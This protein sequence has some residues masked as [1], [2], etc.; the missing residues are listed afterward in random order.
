M[1]SKPHGWT[2]AT[3]G[4]LCRPVHKINPAATNPEEIISYIDIGCINP[5][6][7]TI[8]AIARIPG[9]NA[10]SRA[11]Q[12]VHPGDILIST[13]RTYLKKVA[14]VPPELNGAIAS[15]G[16]CVLRPGPALSPRFLLY[17]VAEDSFIRELSALQTG[18]SYPA[19]RDGDVFSRTIALPALDE[20]VRIVA[21]IEEQ[22]SRLDDG[23]RLLERARQMVA[24]MR[25]AV[26]AQVL[27][28]EWPLKQVSNFATV[29][30]GAT[31]KRGR[32]DYY[33]GG[34]IPWVTSGQLVN[35][36]VEKP[37]EYITEKAMQETSV[38]LWPKHTLLL[39]MYGEGRTRGHCSELLFDATTN[40][41]CAAIVLDEN[42]P[43]RRSYLKLFL[44]ASYDKNRRLAS[45]GVQPN[46]SLKIVRSMN[47]PIPPFEVQDA[48]IS[49][50]DFQLTLVN[51]L[52]TAIDRALIRSKALRR[53]ILQ[54]AFSGQLL[55]PNPSEEPAS[56]LV[57][58]IFAARVTGT[59]H[60]RR[61]GV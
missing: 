13:V 24:R 39:A 4:D 16:F 21:A 27:C 28:G 50:I 33:H 40:Q 34:T 31:P 15:T 51:S 26:F 23:V 10:P 48:I 57:A 7:L 3:I 30:S 59:S 55:P 9:C 32:A 20:Q 58:S 47:V 5:S 36:F 8:D 42:A 44:T 14:I 54:R 53:S 35:S 46:L 61:I 18:S 2:E 60:G 11:R 25:M 17:R 41:A 49:K 6:K 45:G 29:G 52:T 56:E 43:V 19:V 1:S 12:L 22:F 38:K 37:A